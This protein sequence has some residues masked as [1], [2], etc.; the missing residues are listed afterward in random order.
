VVGQKA[1]RPATD[2]SVNRPH[3]VSP[4]GK[5]R[6]R[7][8]I[9][10]NLACLAVYSPGDGGI[11]CRCV[12]FIMPRGKTGFEGFDAGDKSRGI[13][14]NQKAAAAAVFAAARSTAS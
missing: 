13:F 6:D 8:A 10:Q 14:P 7:D 5:P 4:A 11:G 9:S 3:S 1:R 2:S 12:G